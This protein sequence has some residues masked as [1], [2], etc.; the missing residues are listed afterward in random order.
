MWK[1]FSSRDYKNDRV[2]QT[3]SVRKINHFQLSM[4]LS[5]P[6]DEISQLNAHF[7]GRNAEAGD[8]GKRCSNPFSKLKH[9]LRDIHDHNNSNE[10]RGSENFPEMNHPLQ[11]EAPIGPE[12]FVPKE[13][14][15]L[16]EQ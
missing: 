14:S 5:P 1:K 15:N 6:R 13:Q 11:A 16:T 3:P 7:L 2:D 4:R 10:A 8:R 12:S 9:S